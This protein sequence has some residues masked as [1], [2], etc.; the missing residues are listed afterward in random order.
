MAVPVVIDVPHKLGQAGARERLKSRIGE[1]GGHMPGGVGRVRHSWP[2]ENEMAL[3]INAMGQN[4]PAKLEI[5]D[6][7]VRVHVSLPPM[8][9][10]FSGIIGAAVRDQGTKLLT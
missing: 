9:A 6:N 7:V 8:L 1:L 3:E 5:L 2:S 4:I 10:Y